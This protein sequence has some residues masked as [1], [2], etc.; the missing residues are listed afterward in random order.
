VEGNEETPKM[1]F[2]QINYN[3]QRKGLTVSDESV[4]GDL[5]EYYAIASQKVQLLTDYF[6]EL[7]DY[8]FQRALL[9]EADEF[10]TETKYWLGETLTTPPVTKT[11]HPSILVNGQSN[12]VTYNTNQTTYGASILTA[13]D[14][15]T[16]ALNPFDL[17]ALDSVI[18]Q[19]DVGVNNK[20]QKL[21]WKSGPR[22]INYVLKLTETQG[23]QLTTTTGASTAMFALL[24]QV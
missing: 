11:H 23:Q 14:T 18:F 17:A 3:L 13:A 7:S 22:S 12:P 9:T 6:T 4:E 1:R 21:A 19:A 2:R 8:N 10:L 15:T 24:V 16:G 5:T 20:L